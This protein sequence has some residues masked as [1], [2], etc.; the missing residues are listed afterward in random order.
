MHEWNEIS[1]SLT[2][3]E[4]FFVPLIL[5]IRSAGGVSCGQPQTRIARRK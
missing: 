3:R 4:T 2:H 1:K 5:G